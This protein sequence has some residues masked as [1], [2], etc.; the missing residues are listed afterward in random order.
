MGYKEKAIQAVRKMQ[1]IDGYSGGDCIS[2]R[3]V[4]IILGLIPENDG[5]KTHT[6]AESVENVEVKM[7]P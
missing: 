5:T 1:D 6:E 2:R 3:A 7:R 4:L